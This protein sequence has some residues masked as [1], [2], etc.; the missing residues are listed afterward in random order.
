VFKSADDDLDRL[1]RKKSQ[2][3]GRRSQS[4]W[5]SAQIK[6]EERNNRVETVLLDGKNEALESSD[7]PKKESEA[8]N[9]GGLSGI[10]NQIDDS[11]RSNVSN[12]FRASPSNPVRLASSKLSKHNSLDF[13]PQDTYL[14]PLPRSNSIEMQKHH[15]LS[16]LPRP[17]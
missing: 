12:V 17:T 2:E 7:E 4:N 10:L 11:N 8:R 16:S 3:S 5:S 15:S 14:A 13:K 1:S 6:E 9:D